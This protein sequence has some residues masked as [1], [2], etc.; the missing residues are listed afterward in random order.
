LLGSLP[1]Q[2]PSLNIEQAQTL[3]STWKTVPALYSAP[4]PF[5]EVSALSKPHQFALVDERPTSKPVIVGFR[6]DPFR[7]ATHKEFAVF[8][9]VDTCVCPVDLLGYNHIARIASNLWEL[10]ELSHFFSSSAIL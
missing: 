6:D 1:A 10:Q 2:T 5:P 3:L 9:D 7:P 8:P 4:P